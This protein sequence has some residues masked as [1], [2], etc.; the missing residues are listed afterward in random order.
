MAVD[1][2]RHILRP[3]LFLLPA[4][5]AQRAA[6]LALRPSRPWRLKAPFLEIRDSRLETELCGLK[7]GNPIGLAAGFDKN[8]ELVQSLRRLG[9]GYLVVGT[10]TELPQRGNPRPRMLRRVTEEALVNSLGFPGKGVEYAARRLERCGDGGP[11]VVSVSGTEAGSIVRCHR[12]LEP[13]VDAVEVNISSPNTAGLSVF[14]EPGALAA[15]LDALNEGRRKPL[16]VKLPRY[17]ALSGEGGGDERGREMLLGLVRECAR[18]GVDGL[19]LANTRPVQDRGLAVGAGGLSGRPLTEETLAMVADVRGEVS[20]GLAINACGGI[21]T[22]EDAR[23][24]LEAGATTVQLYTALVYHGPGT[25][26]RIGTELL[27]HMGG[28]V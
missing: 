22:G 4:E 5:T 2:Y 23:R 15:L 9:F 26:R 1:L 17:G 24:A 7:L 28:A 10:V 13:L 16:F 8:C 25:V 6:E 12:R 20:D 19:T 27:A 14:Q 3:L 21:F 11:V 18:R